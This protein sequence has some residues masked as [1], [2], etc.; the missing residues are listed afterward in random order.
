MLAFI[1]HFI[2]IAFNL[3]VIVADRNTQIDCP[4][5]TP[6][7]PTTTTP[8]TTT[9]PLIQDLFAS[10][11]NKATVCLGNQTTI[12]IPNNFK[13]YPINVFYGVTTDNTCRTTANDCKVPTQ[14]QCSLQGSCTISLYNDVP[15]A[16]CGNTAIANYIGIEYRFIPLISTK[17]YT[18][19]DSTQ[20]TLTNTTSYGIITNPNYP[21]W[22]S[23]K[24]C[25]R[26]LVAP[27]GRI[28]KVYLNDFALEQPSAIGR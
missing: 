7:S 26:K 22:E 20:I 27:M 3:T 1:K 9:P 8:T 15:V 28:F 25:N 16:E 18:I 21:Q 23:N 2:L 17:N 11:L 6:G 14:L 13:L 19:C 5:D 12:Q 10:T 24:N 4:T